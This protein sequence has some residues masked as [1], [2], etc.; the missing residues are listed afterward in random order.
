[1]TLVDG[2][3]QNYKRSFEAGAAHY[4]YGSEGIRGELFP[5]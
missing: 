3:P 5:D 1:M 2:V 4:D